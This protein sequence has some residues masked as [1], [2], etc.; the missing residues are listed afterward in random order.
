MVSADAVA[1]RKTTRDG[2]IE[3]SGCPIILIVWAVGTSQGAVA[4]SS[5]LQ[6]RSRIT[7]LTSIVHTFSL[8]LLAN[9]GEDNPIFFRFKAFTMSNMMAFVDFWLLLDILSE[10]CARFD[11]PLFGFALPGV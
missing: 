2:S 3:Q 11:A 9:A 4:K 8:I 10:F 7:Y 1:T 6:L 5:R